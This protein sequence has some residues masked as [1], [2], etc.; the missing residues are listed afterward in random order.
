MDLRLYL[1]DQVFDELANLSHGVAIEIRWA[2]GVSFTVFLC[3]HP[4]REGVGDI[5]EQPFVLCHV[6]RLLKLTNVSAQAQFIAF[7]IQG[8]NYFLNGGK[9]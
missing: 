6:C 2:F 5:D 8:K 9:L 3:R 1:H 7:V 4:F